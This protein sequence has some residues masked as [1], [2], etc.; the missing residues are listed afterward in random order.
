MHML[1]RV[2]AGFALFLD[3][4]LLRG[5]SEREKDVEILLLRQQLWIVER[6]LRRLHRLSRWEK[7]QLS[8]VDGTAE[9]GDYGAANACTRS[10]GSAN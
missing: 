9:S 7:S 5:Q 1:A 2:G 6:K 8:D 10:C 3:M 4:R